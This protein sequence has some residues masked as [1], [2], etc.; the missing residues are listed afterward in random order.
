MVSR[1]G[2][3]EF[4]FVFVEFVEVDCVIKVVILVV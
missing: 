3:C 1:E 2:F 4:F